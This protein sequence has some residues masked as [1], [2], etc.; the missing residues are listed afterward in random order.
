MASVTL[1]EA[2]KLGLNDL[3]AGVVE[4]IITVNAMYQVLPFDL[5]Y[6]NALAYNREN[7]L[8]DVQVL[9]VDGTITAK[10]AATYTAKTAGLTIIS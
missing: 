5:I 3:Q 1:A 6:G 9:G 2:S 7:V 10:A 8:G 4:N